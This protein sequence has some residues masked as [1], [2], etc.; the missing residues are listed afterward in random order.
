MSNSTHPLHALWLDPFRALRP[1][2]QS[3]LTD[4]GMDVHV[5]RTLDDLQ[6]F[7]EGTI[8][9]EIHSGISV[10]E[11]THHVSDFNSSCNTLH[12]QLH[13]CHVCSHRVSAKARKQLRHECGY[14]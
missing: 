3:A 7:G 9:L 8:L 13:A 5:V 6:V 1:Q 10:H 11:K 14:T 12:L 2:D 4:L